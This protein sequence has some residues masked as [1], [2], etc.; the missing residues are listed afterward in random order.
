MDVGDIKC[1]MMGL[2]STRYSDPNYF[3]NKCQ[4][5]VELGEVIE[6]SLSDQSSE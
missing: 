5:M 4:H 2:L 3:C 1:K 6:K